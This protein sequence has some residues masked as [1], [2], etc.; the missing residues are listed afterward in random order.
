[1]RAG[2]LLGF[3]GLGFWGLGFCASALA[4][5]TISDVEL[6]K[7]LLTKTGPVALPAGVIEISRELVLPSDAHDLDIRGSKTTIK[8]APAFRGT[9][10]IVVPAGKNIKIHDLSLDGNRDVIAQPLGL[11][12][13]ARCLRALCRTT[14]SLPKA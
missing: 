6:R 14:E 3:C 12:P 8:A 13:P 10:L 5:G 7:A 2:I 1:M 4:A 11:P 9:A